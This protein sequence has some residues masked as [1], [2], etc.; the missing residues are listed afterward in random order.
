MEG[1][2]VYYAVEL[3]GREAGVAGEEEEADECA[4][5]GVSLA[6]SLGKGSWALGKRGQIESDIPA[7]GKRT[8]IVN[9]AK[10]KLN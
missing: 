6:G 1:F 10:V 4:C 7:K 3:E 8:R 5:G 9:V 2:V